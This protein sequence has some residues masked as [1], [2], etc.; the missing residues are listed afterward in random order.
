MS[1]DHIWPIRP[2][3]CDGEVLSSWLGRI[4]DGYNLSFRDFRRTRLPNTPGYSLDIDLAPHPK[5]F[6]VISRGSLLPIEELRQMGYTADEGL[7]FSRKS[8]I[9]PEWI[10]PL[11]PN[12][13]DSIPFCPTC[14]AADETPYYRKRWRYAFAPICP[15]HGLLT[16]HCPSCGAPYSGPSRGG[17]KSARGANGHCPHC[18]HRIR[19]ITIKGLDDRTLTRL[20]GVQEQIFIGLNN[21]WVPVDGEPWVHICLYLRGLH[22][23]I[24]LILN[25][26]QGP[27]I[28]KWIL[29]ESGL[30]CVGRS[31]GSIESQAPIIRAAA[32]GLASWLIGEWPERMKLMV[33]VLNLK[34]STLSYLRTGPNWLLHPNIEFGLR[35]R[36]SLRSKEEIDSARNVL[37]QKRSWVPNKTALNRFMRTGEVPPI[38]PISRPVPDDIKALLNEASE[39]A[40]NIRQ[41]REKLTREER[42]KP[43]ELYRPAVHDCLTK[44]LL[45]NLDD[46]A[47]ILTSLNELKRRNRRKPMSG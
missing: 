31:P 24:V 47:E 10:V 7:V 27:K 39:A 32:L 4:A 40:E 17:R 13:H 42:T 26:E 11:S 20:L 22:D 2:K 3:P 30:P 12:H 45:D 35:T 44:E 21:G 28:A 16:N 36:P 23:L 8:G 9:N 6:E 29:K 25:D 46:T 34:S 19:P 38:Q 33:S 15:E 37:R 14:L 18:L 41:N 43:N 5:L 1:N